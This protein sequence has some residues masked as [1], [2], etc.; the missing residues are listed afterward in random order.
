MV[1]FLDC[2]A[3]KR[4]HTFIESIGYMTVC[5][6]MPASAPAKALMWTFAYEWHERYSHQIAGSESANINS[7]GAPS[8]PS[9]SISST[10][11]TAAAAMLTLAS[12]PCPPEAV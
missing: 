5:S 7:Q 3:G 9:Y 8:N 10:V 2:P 6:E 4:K 12:G 11:D 1:E